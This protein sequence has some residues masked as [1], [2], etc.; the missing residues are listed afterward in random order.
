MAIYKFITSDDLKVSIR[1]LMLNQVTDSDPKIIKN[2]ERKAL[3]SIKSKINN[4]YV[5]DQVFLTIKEWSN[6]TAYSAGE[7]VYK[8]DTFYRAL[9]AGTNKDPVS[10]TTYWVEDDPR[11]GNLVDCCVKITLFHIFQRINPR[12][13]PDHVY[14]NLNDA[15]EWL[16]DVKDG[17]E[18][19][20]LPLKDNG[21]STIQ[22]GS[23]E[24]IEH[25]Y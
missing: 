17:K 20:D 16:N 15:Y 9:K 10:E 1:E 19:P 25:Y 5:I 7:Y 8:T 2:A 3:D 6:A 4:R 22:W 23:N 18:N 13:V 14:D 11:N 24:K 12:K 21:A